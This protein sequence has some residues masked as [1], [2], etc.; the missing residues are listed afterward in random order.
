MTSFLEVHQL[1]VLVTYRGSKSTVNL[2]MLVSSLLLTIIT[3][4]TK[5]YYIRPR[6]C[7]QFP[8]GSRSCAWRIRLPQTCWVIKCWLTGDGT[9]ATNTSRLIPGNT[10]TATCQFRMACKRQH[11]KSWTYSTYH[12][13][14]RHQI[15]ILNQLSNMCILG[16]AWQQQQQQYNCPW[17]LRTYF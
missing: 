8:T 3:H 2:L 17:D 11:I 5:S 15:T 9:Q 13:N 16:I 4:D 7:M 6:M 14:Y 10:L 1:H 12:K